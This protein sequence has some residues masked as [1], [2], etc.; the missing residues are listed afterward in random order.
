MSRNRISGMV[1]AL[2]ALLLGTGA[3][4][5]APALAADAST[6]TFAA[7]ADTFVSSANLAANYG[8]APYVVTDAS[9]VR[10]IFLKFT[11]SGLSGAV[12]SA[13]LRL[14]AYG[15]NDGSDSGGTYRAMSN[16]GWSET[17]VTWGN[18]PMID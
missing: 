8:T 16:A 2:G 17:A 6:T 11:V 1:T 4:V 3:A 15:G 10:R 7:T 12:T 5:V 18:Q 13:R 9:P 14:H